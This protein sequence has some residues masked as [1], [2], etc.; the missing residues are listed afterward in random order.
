MGDQLTAVALDERRERTFVTGPCGF[1][2]P[3]RLFLSSL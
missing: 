3:L 1:E 2:Q